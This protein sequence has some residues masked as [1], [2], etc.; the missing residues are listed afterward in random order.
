MATAHDVAAYILQQKGS[1]TAMK[2]QKLVYYSQAWNLVWDD[3]PIFQ[4]PIQAWAHGP[5]VYELFK[6]HKGK[7]KVERT[8]FA[9]GKP[10]ALNP[11]EVES[12]DVVLNLYGEMS[13]AQLSELTHAELPWKHARG[14]TQESASSS[15]E[16]SHESMKSY[17]SYLSDSDDA[18]HSIEE[19]NFPAWAR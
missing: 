4:E 9:G 5:V 13:G 19:V 15:V 11:D 3:K 12:I 17:Y 6:L 7:Y 14:A 2:L 16:I 1:M 18:V 10:G 8:D